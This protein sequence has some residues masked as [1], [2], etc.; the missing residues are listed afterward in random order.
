MLTL[1]S[2]SGIINAGIVSDSQE[3][4]EDTLLSKE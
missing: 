4:H 3:K 1:M 2:L